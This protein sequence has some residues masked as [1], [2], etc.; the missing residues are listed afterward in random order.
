MSR[1]GSVGLP[2]H[3]TRRIAPHQA[4]YFGNAHSVEIA[5][6]GVLQ[7]ACGDGKFQCLLPV[8]KGVQPVDQSGSETVTAANAGDWNRRSL[9]GVLRRIMISP[10]LT[11][12][13]KRYPFAFLEMATASA[14][15]LEISAYAPL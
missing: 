7:T 15:S 1:P 6:Y 10:K 12:S 9:P 3:S 2:L 11:N 5:G 13:V 4:L 8:F 14:A